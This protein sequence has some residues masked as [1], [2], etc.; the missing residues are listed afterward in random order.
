MLTTQFYT[1][2]SATSAAQLLRCISDI[3]NW[4]TSNRLKLNTKKTQF[5]WLSSSY[6][7]VSV[8]HLPL[9]VG[10]LTVFPDDTVQN[11]G[12]MFDAQLTMGN[13]VDNVVCSCFF[14]LRHLRSI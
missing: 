7:T 13:H 3:A 10:G 9:S 14:Q 12:M 2:C 1:S 11:L 6:F 8:S 5:I 4:M